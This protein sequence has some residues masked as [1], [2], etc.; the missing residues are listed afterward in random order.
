M[1]VLITNVNKDYFKSILPKIEFKDSTKNT[2]TFECS[3]KQFEK[4]C[5]KVKEDGY[6]IYAVMSW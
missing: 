3:K 1:R 6:N 5:N 2:S 4:V